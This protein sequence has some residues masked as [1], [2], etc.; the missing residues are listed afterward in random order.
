MGN[1]CGEIFTY[2]IDGPN[3]V[4]LG[5]GDLHDTN[6][7]HLERFSYFSNLR[8]FPSGQKSYSGLPL[9]TEY[10][11]WWIRAYPSLIAEEQHTT[12]DPIIFTVS[13]VLIFLFTSL[14]FI[15]YDI[16]VERRQVSYFNALKCCT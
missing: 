15:V 7:D 10:C 6:Y 5:Y 3:A 2:Q 11:P 13:A 14:V 1:D 4:Y 8:D 9:T 16:C 12:K